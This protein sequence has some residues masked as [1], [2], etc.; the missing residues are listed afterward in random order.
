MTLTPERE[1]ELA[2]W[3]DYRTVQSSGGYDPTF[4]TELRA[5]SPEWFYDLRTQAQKAEVRRLAESGAPRPTGSSGLGGA[6]ASFLGELTGRYDPELR[7]WLREVRPDWFP[8]LRTAAHKAEVRRLA[9]TGQDRPTRATPLGMALC[10][11][12]AESGRR[13]DPE[14]TLWLRDARPDWFLDL[15]VADQRAQIRRLAETGANRPHGHLPL[16]VALAGFLKE[17]GTRSDPELADWLRETRPDWFPEL[18]VA[19]QKDEIRRL[20]QIGANK[21]HHSTDLGRRLRTY[22]SPSQ[23]SYDEGL[24]TELEA[25][26][27]DWFTR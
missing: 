18:R 6:L 26:R 13:Y 2:R 15:R 5:A 22:I 11:F 20:A 19:A 16:G 17:A 9:E 24:R 21:P 25:L 1:A 14:L 10:A 23:N 3:I 8:D 7:D 4:L 27:P 12:L